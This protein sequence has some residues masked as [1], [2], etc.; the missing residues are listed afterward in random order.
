MMSWFFRNFVGERGARQRPTASP[1]SLACVA[2]ATVT[3]VGFAGID[4]QASQAD[5]IL[6]IAVTGEP[7]TLDPQREVSNVGNPIIAN[8]FDT[9]IVADPSQNY[10]LQPGL[11]ESWT[12]VSPNTLVLHLRQGVKFQD[13]SDFTAD[14]VVFTFDPARILT[15]TWPGA[16]KV[17]W[18]GVTFTKTNDF[19]VRVTTDQPDHVLEYRLAH[20]TGSIISRSAFRRS[21]SL[22]AW[23]RAPV[24]T[25]PYS[26]AEFR[27]GDAIILRA[28]NAYWG[29]PPPVAQIR[30]QVV[31][32]VASRLAGL[33]SGDY[34][35]V[36]NLPPD[37]LAQVERHGALEVTGGPVNNILLYVFDTKNELYKDKRIR[38]AINLCIDR[39]QIVDGLWSGRTVVPN[40]NQYGA[41]KDL[42]IEDHP[43]PSYDPE[44]AAI[45]AR[46]AGYKGEP[47]PLRIRAN[48]YPNEISTAEAAA[49]MCLDAGINLKIEVKENSDEMWGALRAY[50]NSMQYPDPLGGILRNWGPGSNEEKRGI[51]TNVKTAGFFADVATIKTSF[52]V[53]ERKAAFSRVLD[54][55]DEEAPGVILYQNANFYGKTRSINWSAPPSFDMDFRPSKL[56]FGTN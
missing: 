32:E 40:G 51:L 6:R 31:P 22:D 16:M 3:I 19:E 45:L 30:W 27:S 1:R 43:G 14:D 33:V 8:I 55:W 17:Y 48:Y 50:S 2:L 38:Q 26:V 15:D 49:A 25:G 39:K 23:S 20:S 44:R 24:G 29:G 5:R 13:G 18:Q 46:E 10:Q 41:F 52:D 4:V 37:Q 28:N 47:L 56:S 7:G 35:I 36:T 34:D 53:S 9:L 21:K 12:R 42:F 54:W 11:A